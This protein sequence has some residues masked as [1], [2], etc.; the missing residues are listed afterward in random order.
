MSCGVI[1]SGDPRLYLLRFEV[2]KNQRTP[3]HFKASSAF[4]EVIELV[5]QPL[6]EREAAGNR[7]VQ[8][9]LWVGVGV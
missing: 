9:Y 5:S 7:G 2:G 4:V 8:K 1:P 6:F 3:A